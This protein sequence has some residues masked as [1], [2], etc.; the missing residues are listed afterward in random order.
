MHKLDV[1]VIY[2]GDVIEKLMQIETGIAEASC[3]VDESLN[4]L[5]DDGILSAEEISE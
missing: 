5:F 3:G 4:A 2:V 1:D